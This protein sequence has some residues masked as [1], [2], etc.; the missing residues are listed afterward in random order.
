MDN[1][2]KLIKEAYGK[3]TKLDEFAFPS[4]GGGWKTDG[5]IADAIE[6]GTKRI[7]GLANREKLTSYSKQL[8]QVYFDVV[9]LADTFSR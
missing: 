5:D 1:D 9:R 7:A 3:V 6:Q 8:Q 4:S 2:S